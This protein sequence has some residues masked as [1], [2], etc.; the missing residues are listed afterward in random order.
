MLPQRRCNHKHPDE[1]PAI[2]ERIKQCRRIPH[3]ET[4]RVR[5]DGS[6]VEVSLTISPIKNAKGQIIG[7]SKIAR[8]I[9][10]RRHAERMTRFPA[11]AS[12]TLA[13]LTDYESTLQRVA[14]LAVPSFADW[15]A[16]DMR[17]A[18]G[19]GA[20]KYE[21]AAGCNGP[22]LFRPVRTRS[23]GQ[24]IDRPGEIAA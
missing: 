15:C 18:N 11:D 3:Y 17:E 2:I 8:D 10:K 22:R 9:S 24:S 16:I 7:A 4:M 23:G 19:N 20:G 5:K 14:S 1:L 6:R 13:E 12:A 21:G